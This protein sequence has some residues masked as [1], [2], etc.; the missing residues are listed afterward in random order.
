MAI[1]IDRFFVKIISLLLFISGCSPGLVYTDIVR[2]YC[3]D[4]R[5][6]D[7]GD[8][9]AYGD[10]KEVEIPTSRIIRIDLSA[11]W[12]SR[13]IGD[14]AKSHGMKVVNGCDRRVI[15]VL[16]GLWKQQEIIVY[17]R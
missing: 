14:I 2:P 17:G 7:L 3:K 12:D 11:Q 15:S 9:I 5:G 10:T 8:K 1:K 6:T 13:A 4:L 16:G